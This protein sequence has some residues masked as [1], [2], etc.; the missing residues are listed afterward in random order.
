M[1]RLTVGTKLVGLILIAILSVVIAGMAGIVELNRISQ[2]TI[3]LSAGAL[4]N[5]YTTAIQLDLVS[6]RKAFSE[7]LAL[8]DPQ[9]L[10]DPVEQPRRSLNANATSLIQAL[11]EQ[12][13]T[14]QADEVS[15]LH[16]S[17]NSELD[18]M[19]SLAKEGRWNTAHL[20]LINQV[21]P[22]EAQFQT[23]TRTL[24]ESL[25]RD[26]TITIETV[27][28]TQRRVIWNMSLI[29]LGALLVLG[30]GSGLLWRNLVRPLANL[31]EV[32]KAIAGG[33]LDMRVQFPGR[34]D[35]IGSLANAFNAMTVQL[36]QTLQG[37]E[38]REEKYRTL[39]QKIQ[40]AVVVH[41]ADTQI[42]TSNSMA[43]ELLGLTED[44]MLGKAAIDSAWHFF[45]ET[46]TTMPLE[47]YPVNQVL[48]SRKALRNFIA[49]VHRPNKEND[50]WVLVNADPVF[51]K[52]DE[53]TQVIVTFI[54]ITERKQAEEEIRKLNQELEQR[55]VERTAQLEAVNK[56]LEAF[57][58]SVSHDLRAPLRHIDGFI[59][60]LQKRAK[61]TLDDQS[62]HYMEVIADSAKKM[63]TLIDDLL[64][65]SRMGRNEMFKSQ[66]DLDELVQDIIQE[67][68]PETEGKDIQWKISPLP[69]V[70]GDRAMLRVVLVNLIF[71]AL[72]F[73]RSRQQA[74]IEIGY[75][76]DKKDETIVFIR[77][78]GVGFDMNYA[79][80]LFGVFQRLHR[81]EDF[82]GTGIGLANVRRVIDRH[83]GRTWADGQVDH[84]ST[85]YFSL[86]L[87]NRRHP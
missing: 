19:I 87:Q 42:L 75:M 38:Q 73:T 45:L 2:Q 5:R 35:E 8:Q 49:G 20:S 22:I 44:Q 16:A 11:N 67:L 9:W 58:Y 77:D 18:N 53:I 40:A 1:L 62:Q 55:V 39:I 51:I 30:L 76:P 54:D 63:G 28:A 10:G 43:Q 57:S 7:G 36:Q 59:E 15:A 65:F 72:K 81:Q 84:G 31:T 66:V 83:G 61:T 24:G 74:E 4:A 86:P 3:Q 64:S 27:H 71:N 50:V 47:K 79:D 68:K 34:G 6:I 69:L 85:F 37:L 29:T 78:N 12:G 21:E 41:G 52:E 25:E 70:T 56:E 14:T 46:G 48:A 26:I 80:K 82:E 23:Q 33:K 13:N 32:A 17:L 60:M